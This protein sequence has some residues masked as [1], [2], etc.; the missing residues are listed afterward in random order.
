[1]LLRSAV[2]GHNLQLYLVIV[3]ILIIIIKLNHSTFVTGFQNRSPSFR[4][5]TSVTNGAA[6]DDPPFVEMLHIVPGEPF[7]LANQTTLELQEALIK[8]FESYYADEKEVKLPKC[9]TLDL[10]RFESSGILTP[11]DQYSERPALAIALALFDSEIILPALSSTIIGVIGILQKRYTI[12]ISIYENG[13]TDKT[14]EFL[15]EFAAALVAMNVKTI[16]FR[17]SNTQTTDKS[18][19]Q[20][21]AEIRNEA[22]LPLL[23]V[24]NAS[25][26]DL[27][28]INDVITCPFDLLELL[29]Q[30]HLQKAHMAAS[31]DWNTIYEDDPLPQPQLYDK[32]VT[33]G[34]NG[35]MAYPF[36]Y[37]EV[38]EAPTGHWVDS[39][40][41]TQSVADRKRWLDGLP[42]PLYSG[43]NGAVAMRM[44]LFT[45]LHL[46]FRASYFPSTAKQ[47]DASGLLGE[48]GKLLAS[49]G[50]I[51]SDCSSSECKLIA[52][53]MWHLLGRKARIVLASQSRTTYNV[54]A[55]IAL[56]QGLFSVPMIARRGKEPDP[57]L[58]LI[59]WDEITMPETVDCW[60]SLDEQG[61]FVQVFQPGK[62]NVTVIDDRFN[63]YTAPSSSNPYIYNYD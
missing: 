62:K 18:K 36:K 4:S 57:S 59:D 27:L 34:I 22:L 28:F 44:N 26:G 17:G 52:R 46:R 13:S 5:K 20:A 55:W 41:L 25:K 12:H 39:L 47:G 54:K 6:A 9:P 3:T 11:V 48:W 50:Y 49:P 63:G 8:R 29:H 24:R 16:V 42:L 60:S 38:W 32:W 37:P 2:Q 56:T 43:W 10:A 19:I 45:D 1:M 21:L 30:L 14:R 35:R 23:R 61:N 15:G 51:A 33:R 31:T 58:E 53:D 7:L 40:W